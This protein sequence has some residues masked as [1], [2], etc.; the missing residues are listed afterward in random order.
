[1][2]LSGNGAP[3]PAGDTA[4]G[5]REM[6]RTYEHATC[7]GCSTNVLRRVHDPVTLIGDATGANLLGCYVPWRS[8]G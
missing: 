4:A 6:M 7:I 2:R 1:M 8:T 5:Q 3:M